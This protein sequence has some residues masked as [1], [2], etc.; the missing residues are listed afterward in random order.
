MLKI[1]AGSAAGAGAGATA[2]VSARR[3]MARRAIG[4]MIVAQ[5]VASVAM[6]PRRRT[7]WLFSHA[8]DMGH[9]VPGPLRAG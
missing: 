3:G 5:I 8:H 1:G 2:G 4:Q 7:S 9:M 6:R